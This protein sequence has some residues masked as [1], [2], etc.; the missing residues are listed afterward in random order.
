M[1]FASKETYQQLVAFGFNKLP[2]KQYWSDLHQTILA[3]AMIDYIADNLNNPEIW[4]KFEFILEAIF[5][6]EEFY[7]LFTDAFAEYIGHRV[8]AE[9]ILERARN[10]ELMWRQECVELFKRIEKVHAEYIDKESNKE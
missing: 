4:V 5:Q 2:D 9:S 3:S 1:R 6:D 8:F 10:G 7:K